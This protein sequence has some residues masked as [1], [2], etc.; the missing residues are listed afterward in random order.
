MSFA[1]PIRRRHLLS[2]QRWRMR[3]VFWGGALAVGIVGVA[4]AWMANRASDL[5]QHLMVRPWLAFLI[6]P[7]AFMLSVWLTRRYFAGAQGSGIPQAIAA[8]RCCRC[9]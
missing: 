1:P 2:G 3:F 7:A 5:F 6:T 8:T 9:G 4:F